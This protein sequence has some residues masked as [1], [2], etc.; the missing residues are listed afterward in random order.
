MGVDSLMRRSA[1]LQI[2]KYFGLRE[3]SVVIG[4]NLVEV[5]GQSWHTALG[6]VATQIAIVVAIC[7]VESLFGFLRHLL[8]IGAGHGAATKAK[9]NR[10]C[11]GDRYA[12]L[13]AS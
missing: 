13:D 4:V 6:F 9:K 1:L 11:N 2:G 12:S 3:L 10:S 5:L 7:R 8:T